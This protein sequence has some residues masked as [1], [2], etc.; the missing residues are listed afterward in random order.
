MTSRLALPSLPSRIVCL[1]VLAAAVFSCSRD[2]VVAPRGL[3]SD[4]A[5]STGKSP[6]AFAVTSTNPSFGDQGTT[7]DVHIV[8]SGFTTGAQ[9]TWLLHGAADPAHVRTNRTTFVSSTELVANITIATDAQLDFWDVQIA[10]IGGKNGVGSELF[11]V[12]SAQILG[13]GTPGGDAWVY[14]MSQNPQVVGYGTGGIN[15]A[16]VY[17]DVAGMVSLGAGQAW[18]I[19]PLGTLVAGRDGNFIAT[20]WVQQSPSTWVAEQLPRLPFSVGSNAMAAARAPDGTLLVAGFDDSAT[21]TKGNA[22]QSNRPVVWQRSGSS[23]SAPQRYLL[24]AGSSRGTARAVNGLG[25]I[26]GRLD[27]GPTGAVWENPTTSTRLD[28]I[29]SA[30]NATGTLIVGERSIPGSNT[31]ATIPVYWQRNPSTGL[32][33]ATATVLPSLAGTSCTSGTVRGLN[34]AGILVGN[35]CNAAGKTQATVWRLDLSGPA[36]V[37]VAGPAGLPG[38]GTGPK[39]SAKALSAAVS[40]S[41]TS[42]FIVAGMALDNG[43]NQLAVRWRIILQ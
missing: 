41:E 21:S 24:P 43:V 28:G 40:V 25:Q 30:I 8:G 35:S 10:L 4:A 36:P 18:T 15:T 2:P 17:D 22:P 12:T 6:T 29:P 3:T 9:A 33:N 13:P 7:I 42:P 16:F 23:W 38:L 34:S 14:G 32:W 19:D 11:E 26:A 37:L 5:P 39:T 27:T 1:G 20:A 31:G